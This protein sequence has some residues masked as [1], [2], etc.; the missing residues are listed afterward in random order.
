VHGKYASLVVAERFGSATMAHMAGR[1]LLVGLSAMIVLVVAAAPALAGDLFLTQVSK[2]R[3]GTYGTD[4]HLNLPPDGKKRAFFKMTN[5]T[6]ES[7]EATFSQGPTEGSPKIKLRWYRGAQDITSDVKGDGYAETIDATSSIV[8]KL[9]A[10]R[11]GAGA[12]CTSGVGDT[13]TA[14]TLAYVA[15][16]DICSTR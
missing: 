9:K 16:N 10:R 4:V 6:A 12:K 1:G 14:H 2:T 15:I 11:T 13:E 7:V 8:I 5:N 3:D